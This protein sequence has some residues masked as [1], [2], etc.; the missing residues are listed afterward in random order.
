MAMGQTMFSKKYALNNVWIHEQVEKNHAINLY[1]KLAPKTI[2][3]YIELIVI[4]L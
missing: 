4:V 3:Y 2:T 1:Y